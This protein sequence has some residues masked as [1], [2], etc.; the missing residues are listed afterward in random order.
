M[1]TIPTELSIRS[2][3]L[4]SW[5]HQI[6]RINSIAKESDK[7][8]RIISIAFHY[9]PCVCPEHIQCLFTVVQKT[10]CE[11][12]FETLRRVLSMKTISN[13]HTGCTDSGTT[14]LEKPIWTKY[15]D[16]HQLQELNMK[17]QRSV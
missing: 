2:C 7:M 6:I 8:A 10:H 15:F 9:T 13:Q 4:I 1:H 14:Y 12:K 16:K 11:P 17:W 5:C 3:S